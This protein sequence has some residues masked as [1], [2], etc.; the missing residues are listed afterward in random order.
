MN[1]SEAI[2]AILESSGSKITSVQFVKK[3][4]D[5]RTIQF[6]PRDRNEIKGTG[7]ANQNP[8]II[9]VRD[10][11]IAKEN[12][13]GAWRSFNVNRVQYIKSNGLVYNFSGL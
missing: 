8:D 6:N 11:R 5:I 9:R 4:G 12:G 3:N 2:R 13:H 1:R 10:L 7:T